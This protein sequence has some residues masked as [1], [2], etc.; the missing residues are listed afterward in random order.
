MV[1]TNTSVFVFAF[2]GAFTKYKSL[3]F[4]L[5]LPAAVCTMGQPPY[6]NDCVIFNTVNRP[7]NSTFKANV[8]NKFLT[9][10]TNFSVNT[11]VAVDI[12]MNNNTI[13]CGKIPSGKDLYHIETSQLFYSAD[14]SDGL[15]MVLVFEKSEFN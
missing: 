10:L 6:K 14:Q 7:V 5:I 13:V 12:S 3:A 11:N 15:C 8:F 4:L 9:F 2:F 1:F